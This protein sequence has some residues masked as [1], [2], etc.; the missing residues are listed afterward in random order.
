M[1]AGVAALAAV[2]MSV[3]TAKPQQSALQKQLRSV[4]KCADC[5]KADC[6]IPH[7]RKRLQMV[8]AS[9]FD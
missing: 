2:F 1:A 3:A 9:Q 4:L 6:P 7:I 8:H 5:K